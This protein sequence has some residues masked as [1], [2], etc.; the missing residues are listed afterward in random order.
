MNFAVA[1]LIAC[2]CVSLAEGPEWPPAD[3]YVNAAVAC[4]GSADRDGC[5]VTRT[6]WAKTY[7]DAIAGVRE[8]QRH[9]SLC[10]STGCDHAVRADAVLGCAWRMV[11]AGSPD[12]KRDEADADDLTQFCGSAYLDDAG[13]KAAGVQARFM[14]ELLAKAP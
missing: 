4:D 2:G 1:A 6:V 3:D 13:R 11:I 10:L 8:S 5:E 7:S 14:R 9:V 12:P